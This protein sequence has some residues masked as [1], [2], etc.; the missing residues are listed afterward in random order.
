MYVHTYIHAYICTCIL[1]AQQILDSLLIGSLQYTECDLFCIFR[2][3]CTVPSI[4]LLHVSR[5]LSLLIGCQIILTKEM[6]GLLLRLP[7][8]TRNFYVDGFKPQ[9]HWSSLCTV[10]IC[11]Y[12]YTIHYV[13]RRR[14]L[15]PRFVTPPGVQNTEDCTSNLIQM[16]FSLCTLSLIWQPLLHGDSILCIIHTCVY[17]GHNFR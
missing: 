4:F 15:V 11:T 14:V 10:F 12:I 1:Y 2:H 16:N 8:V 9:P 13:C 7:K 6:E 3:F 5:V 17:G